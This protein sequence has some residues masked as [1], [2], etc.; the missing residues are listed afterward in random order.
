MTTSPVPRYM[1]LSV[2]LVV[3]VP[4][5][6][7]LVAIVSVSKALQNYHQVYETFLFSSDN[8]MPNSIYRPRIS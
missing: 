5:I 8:C 4:K 1:M 3:L 2:G 6:I 7:S